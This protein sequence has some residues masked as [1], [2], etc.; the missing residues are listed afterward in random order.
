MLVS[1]AVHCCRPVC[2]RAK[3]VPLEVW[4]PP[5]LPS[6]S[7]PPTRPGRVA[8]Q[9]P[10]RQPVFTGFQLEHVDLTDYAGSILHDH[11]STCGSESLAADNRN[12]STP[13]QVQLAVVGGTV[14]L[15]C[16]AKV[17]AA[18]SKGVMQ[19]T[20]Y[21]C[22]E[23]SAVRHQQSVWLHCVASLLNMNECLGMQAR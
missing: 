19:R 11:H 16:R 13:C 21:S 9:L 18:S 3:A 10:V 1:Q 22:G 15:L 2:D 5:I 20:A 6:P 17:A 12:C 7:P 23:N 4:R 14:A 8:H